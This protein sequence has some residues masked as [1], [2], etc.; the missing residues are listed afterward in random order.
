MSHRILPRRRGDPD[1]AVFNRQRALHLPG[2]LVIS[3]SSTQASST[4]P[5]QVARLA[6]S[7]LEE[8]PMHRRF[9]ENAL[10]HTTPDERHRLNTYLEYCRDKGLEPDY[11]T[12]CYLTI[13]EEFLTK[14]EIG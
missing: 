10:A 3:E 8:N 12:R 7:I 1:R 4:L 13:V 2:V 9:L 6:E 5:P 11:I 14:V